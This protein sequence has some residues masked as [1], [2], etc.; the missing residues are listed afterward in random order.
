MRGA[1]NECLP[2]G[3]VSVFP[4]C[5]SRSS[6]LSSQARNYVSSALK[7]YMF[8]FRPHMFLFRMVAFESLFVS[9]AVGSLLSFL[10]KLAGSPL[11]C[12]WFTFIV[13]PQVGRPL[14]LLC[15]WFTFIV[16]PQVGRPLFMCFCLVRFF[17]RVRN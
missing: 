16:P 17:A 5:I 1:S 14:P 11:L 6:S 7:I 8:L 4:S 10:Q 12:F 3:R 13:P 15:F 2:G 9:V